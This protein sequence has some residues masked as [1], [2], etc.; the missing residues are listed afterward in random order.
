MENI[1]DI[2]TKIKSGVALVS[3]YQ[4]GEKIASGSAFL[5]KNKIISNNHVFH[6]EGESFNSSVDVKIKILNSEF[7]FKYS[8]LGQHVIIGSPINTNDYIVLDIKNEEFF[9]DKFQFELGSHENVEVGDQILIA[10]YPFEHE[11][12]TSH[13]GHVSAKYFEVGVNIIQL[14]ASV[15]NG[16]SGGPLIDPKTVK[17]VGIVT[18][19]ATGLT[20]QFDDLIS[21][22]NYNA[23]MLSKL[24]GLSW[25]DLTIGNIL[26]TSQGQMKEI[27]RNIKRSANVGIGYAFSCDKL[28][29]E[30]FYQEYENQ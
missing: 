30:N 25:G 8:D 4:N 28:K 13:V 3:F 19:K 18:R 12:L 17:V 11:N 29:E 2:I 5:C 16:N 22:F 1:T 20:K 27:A 14:D 6:P 15:N 21:S 26:A 9:K 7:V 24:Q 23:S 10:G